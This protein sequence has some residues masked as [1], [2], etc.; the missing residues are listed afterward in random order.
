LSNEI[1]STKTESFRELKTLQD[2]SNLLGCSRAKLR[3]LLYRMPRFRRYRVFELTKKAGGPRAIHSPVPELKEL[4]QRLH[5]LFSD[6]Y[7]PKHST[8]GFARDRSI[9]TNA[10]AHVGTGAILNIDLKDFF[11]SIHIG[12]VIGRL[13]VRPFECPK[14]GATI[15]AQLCCHNGSLPQGAPTSP[16]VS[17]LICSRLDVDLRRLASERRCRYTRYA[18][19]ITFSTR[20]HMFPSDIV[21][22]TDDGPTLGIAIQRIISKHNFQINYAKVRFQP[23]SQR[24]VVTGLKVNRFPNPSRRLLSQVRAMLHALEKF[25]KD[26]AQREYIQR[27]ARKH[28]APYRGQASF[29]HALRGK[30]E[31][32]GCIRGRSSPIF[33]RFARKLRDQAPEVVRDWDVRTLA[34]RISDAVWVI[35]SEATSTQGTGFFLKGV[36]FLTCAH[37]VHSDSVAFRASDHAAKFPLRVRHCEPT[38]DLA[39]CDFDVSNP[40]SLTRAVSRPV[41]QT[42]SIILAGF[43]NFRYG[44]TPRISPGVVVSFR[45]VSAIRRVVINTAIISGNSGG[46]VLNSDGAVIGVAVTGTDR[47]DLPEVTA[48]YGVIPIDALDHFIDSAPTDPTAD[49]NV[50]PVIPT[51]S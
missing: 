24:Q 43:P 3:Y 47:F 39:I 6:A 14:K 34:E 7:R 45:T 33:I 16:I 31:F 21:S 17:N 35:E 41:K 42:D 19:D 49:E 22:V 8:H 36:G 32:V 51:S 18:D 50:A 5:K 37:V 38:I 25:G 1:V 12:R 4:Q 10:R 46:P 20:G 40:P 30:I 11:P 29:M 48:D 9:L 13:R 26:S 28:R 15:L 27:F 2:V 23:R 44:D